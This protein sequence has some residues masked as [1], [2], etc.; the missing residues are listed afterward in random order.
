MSVWNDGDPG[1]P[2]IKDLESHFGAKW[3]YGDSTKR[4]VV[5]DMRNLA[6][7]LEATSKQVSEV[8]A[9]YGDFRNGKLASPSTL[10]RFVREHAVRRL[11]GA[12]ERRKRGASLSSIAAAKRQRM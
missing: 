10:R 5:R 1:Q 6:K 7:Y 11:P 8:E 3:R 4:E 9:L 12:K 2:P